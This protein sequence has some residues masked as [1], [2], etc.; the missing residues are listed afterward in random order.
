[1]SDELTVLTTEHYT[2]QS[3]RQACLQDMQGRAT[4]FLY[5]VSA[6]LVALGFMS[7]A[8]GSRQQFIVFSVTLLSALWVLGILT[9]L[10]VGQLAVEDTIIVFGI[11][12]IRHRYLELQPALEGVFVRAIHD[13]L[14]GLQEEMDASRAWWQSLMPVTTV[15]SFVD[16]VVVGADL[17]VILSASLHVSLMLAVIAGVLAGVLNM[18]VL[19]LIS[20]SL[21]AGLE[22]YPA[23]FPSSSKAS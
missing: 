17:S 1:M 21:W 16:S 18:I 4:L 2:L 20:A 9:F 8:S 6:V 3:A 7:S 19:T 10:R 12:R 23:R 11:S 14:T 22:R 15:V 5:S 13:D